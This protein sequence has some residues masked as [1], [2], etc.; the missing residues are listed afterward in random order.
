MVIG[1]PVSGRTHKDTEDILGMFV[2]TLAM[3]SYPERDKSFEQ[4]LSEVKNLSIKAFDNQE[5]PL[6]DLVEEVVERS[7]LSRNPLFDVLISP[8]K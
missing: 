8:T 7:D 6:E 4:L 2:N 3:R 1:S 5:Y